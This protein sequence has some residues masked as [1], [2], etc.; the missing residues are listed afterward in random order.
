VQRTGKCSGSL[1]QAVDLLEPGD[2]QVPTGGWR[3]RHRPF[4][5][6]H[7]SMFCVLGSCSWFDRRRRTRSQVVGQMT[8]AYDT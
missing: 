1:T 4:T 8:Q 7:S 3:G 2:D 5:V 6:V